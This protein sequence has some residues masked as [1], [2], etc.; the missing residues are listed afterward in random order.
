MIFCKTLAV[1]V[2]LAGLFTGTYIARVANE[3]NEFLGIVILAGSIGLSKKLW[4]EI[5]RR[6]VYVFPLGFSNYLLDSDGCFG[7]AIH[8]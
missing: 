8:R 1:M 2:F 5:R 6:E 3:P 7:M 4:S